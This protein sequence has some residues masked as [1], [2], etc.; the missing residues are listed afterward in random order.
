[1]SVYVC[2][3]V[4]EREIIMNVVNIRINYNDYI[5]ISLQVGTRQLPNPAQLFKLNHS[6]MNSC[7]II[8]YTKENLYLVKN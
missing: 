4:C 1:M 7:Y 2:V 6:L 8:D 3:S 5:V